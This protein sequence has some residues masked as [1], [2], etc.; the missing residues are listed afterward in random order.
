M[1]IAFWVLEERKGDYFED[2]NWEFCEN[3]LL[4]EFF[5]FNL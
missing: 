5:V 2:G 4:R 1:A 3:E